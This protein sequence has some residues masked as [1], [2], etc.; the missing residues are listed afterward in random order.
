MKITRM[1]CN[2]IHN[3]RFIME[4]PNGNANY[5]L[6][7]VKSPAVFELNNTII[8]VKPNHL[9]IFDKGFPYKY[10]ASNS[11]YINDWLYFDNCEHDFLTP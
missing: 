2:S 9:I 5:L 10:S 6:L 3:A 7:Y 4:R 1:G 8:N 11:N